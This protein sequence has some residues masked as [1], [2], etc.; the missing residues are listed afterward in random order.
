MKALPNSSSGVAT[1]AARDES[2]RAIGTL[3]VTLTPDT[4]D[5]SPV[6]RDQFG[7]SWVLRQSLV[8]PEARYYER[9]RC[10]EAWLEVLP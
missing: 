1:L 8:H 3:V 5:P 10:G 9:A 2:G 6:V 4:A 7:R